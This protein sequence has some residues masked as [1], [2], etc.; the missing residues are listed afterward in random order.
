MVNVMMFFPLSFLT[1][2]HQ[3]IVPR[4]GS[5]L[6]VCLIGLVKEWTRAITAPARVLG[7]SVKVP[8]TAVACGLLGHG[9]QGLSRTLG[10]TWL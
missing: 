3:Q 8:K 9:M 4:K 5:G 10:Q 6:I 1:P 7:D 2:F